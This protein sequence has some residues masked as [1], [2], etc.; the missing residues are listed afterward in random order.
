MFPTIF[1]LASEGLGERAAE[2]SGL[3]CVAIVGGAIVPLITGYAADAAGLRLALAV[4]ALCYLLILAFGWY[5]RR[6]LQRG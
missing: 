1:T 3:I 2:G 6:P 4:P 5:A